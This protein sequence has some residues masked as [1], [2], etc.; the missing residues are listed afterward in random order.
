MHKLKI[1]HPKPFKLLR[2]TG[3][4]LLV[5]SPLY[6]HCD[7]LYLGHSPK[8]TAARFYSAPDQQ[9]LDNGLTWLGEQLGQQLQP[10]EA[11]STS[12]PSPSAPS[13]TES[14]P[15]HLGSSFGITTREHA[16]APRCRVSSRPLARTRRPVAVPYRFPADE[17]ARRPDLLRS[18]FPGRRAWGF[19]VRYLGLPR[20]KQLPSAPRWAATRPAASLGSEPQPSPTTPPPM[21]K[22]ADLI[23]S[24]VPSQGGEPGRILPPK[25][26][27]YHEGTLGGPRRTASPAACLGS[28]PYRTPTASPPMKKPTAPNSSGAPS[29]GGEPGGFFAEI[30]KLL[31]GNIGQSPPHLATAAM[32]PALDRSKFAHGSLPGAASL[33]GFFLR[34]FEITTR[35][36]NGVP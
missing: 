27:D 24:E 8:G 6:R 35:E 18:P 36:G 22:P 30:A 33:G 13:T 14:S 20:G 16:G 28:D 7:V 4:S 11:K 17:Q 19:S 15:S 31:Q 1:K 3:S 21:K 34:D 9:T 32:N 10:V 5:S 2:K 29:Q 25:F 23:S 26:C 12:Q